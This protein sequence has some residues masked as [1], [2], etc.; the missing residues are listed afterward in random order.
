MLAKNTLRPFG[1]LAWFFN[2]LQPQGSWSVLG[3]L[4]PEDRCLTASIALQTRGITTRTTLLQL[5]PT[6]LET[7]LELPEIRKKITLQLHNATTSGFEIRNQMPVLATSDEI[8]NLAFEIANECESQVLLDVSTMPKRYFFPLLMALCETD[9]IQTL[10]VTNTS[11]KSYGKV[12]S[13]DASEWDTLPGFSALGSEETSETTVMIGVGY[14]LL[15]IR[16]LLERYARKPVRFR[17][18]LPVPSLHPGFINNWQ[19]IHGI[20]THWGARTS[21]GPRQV[22]PEIIRVPTH[23]VSL[24]FDRLVQHSQ[25]GRAPSLVMAP[26]GPKPLSVAMCLL[27]IARQ[28]GGQFE[29]EIGYT[30]PRV[31]SPDYSSGSSDV[32]AFCIKLNGRSLYSL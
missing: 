32:T 25:Q 15:N 5:E 8:N 4:S 17:L 27:G 6:D 12:L 31:Y 21:D 22:E 16:E 11:P 24:A 7:N 20:K 9:R 18:M 13:E 26:F 10:V 19:F 3:A 28:A 23:D 2:R 30:Q 29:T 1:P 14:Q